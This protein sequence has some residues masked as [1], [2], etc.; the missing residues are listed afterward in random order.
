MKLTKTEIL[1]SKNWNFTRNPLFPRQEHQIEKRKDK[2]TRAHVET[3]NKQYHP[4]VS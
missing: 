2:T 3:F 4:E 1:F